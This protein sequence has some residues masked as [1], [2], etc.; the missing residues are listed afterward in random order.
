MTYE[1][2]LQYLYASLPVFQHQGAS[3]YKPGLE[4]TMSLDGRLGH[5]HAGYATIH[6]AGTNGKGSV[7]HLLAAIL[8]QAGY[9]TGLYTSPHLVDFRER[10]RVNGKMIPEAYIRDFVAQHR[11]FFEPLKPSFF[12]LTSTMAFDYFLK[13]EVDI[14][15]VETGLGGRLDSTNII[16][17]ILSI[18]TGISLDH[19]LLLGGTT[20][21]IARE[22]AGIIKESVPVVVG[23]MDSPDAEEVFRKRAQELN[24]SLHTPREERVLTHA[25]YLPKER[26]WAY[27]SVDYGQLSGQLPGLSQRINAETVLCALRVLADGGIP[28]PREAVREG[29][30]QVVRL[31]GLQGRWQEVSSAPYTVCDTGHNADAWRY[32]TPQIE[33]EA[34]GRPR[35]YL[36]IGLSNDKD[37]DGIL[38]EMPQ[39]ASY[40]FTQASTARALPAGELAC[41]AGKAGLTGRACGT[42]EEAVR[43]AMREAG[44]EDMV[45]IGGS[46]FVVAEALPL[47]ST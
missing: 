44:K 6:V 1:E 17:P 15:V 39:K 12:E 20:V 22:K 30:E 45:F 33:A 46:N 26:R 38:K 11:P 19:T 13:E 42:V 40:L 29:F 10:I 21:E 41:R 43:R 2:T 3:A 14:A 47:F 23:R 27:E 31:T 8:Q 32:L 28:I 4:T 5:P 9:R 7:C 36:I 34:E 35:L 18:I 37:I 16:T 25:A 24:A